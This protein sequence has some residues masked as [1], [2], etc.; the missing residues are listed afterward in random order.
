MQEGAELTIWTSSLSMEQVDYRPCKP[1][2]LSCPT[3]APHQCADGGVTKGHMTTKSSHPLA[4]AVTQS[5][6]MKTQPLSQT[7]SY[8]HAAPVPTKILPLCCQLVFSLFTCTAKFNAT[9]QAL[10]HTRSS[11]AISFLGA[12]DFIN[13][14]E[15]ICTVH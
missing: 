3:T 8:N 1:T 4:S 2:A 13:T 6:E 12:L 11:K 9:Q 14:H 10:F 5:P 7:R 15:C